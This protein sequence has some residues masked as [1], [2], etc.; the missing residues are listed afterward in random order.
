M[1][2][3]IFCSRQNKFF[4]IQ[5]AYAGVNRSL[6]RMRLISPDYYPKKNSKKNFLTKLL[7]NTTPQQ[8]RASLIRLTSENVQDLAAPW[9]NLIR[10][11]TFSSSA[12]DYKAEKL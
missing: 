3:L 9:R 5:F 6:D 2:D 4:A 7:K 8:P 10:S 11:N 12:F 1:S